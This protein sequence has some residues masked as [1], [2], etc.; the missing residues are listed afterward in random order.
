MNQEDTCK[1]NWQNQFIDCTKCDCQVD[2][3]NLD[4]WSFHFWNGVENKYPLCCI[5]W[6]CDSWC[7]EGQQLGGI[8]EHFFTDYFGK[9]G[10]EPIGLHIDRILCPD[11][12]ITC[13]NKIQKG[14]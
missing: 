7:N 2:I 1:H 4:K 6:F 13:I 8:L 5:L 10:I 12:L 11:C 14:D 9:D 3:T